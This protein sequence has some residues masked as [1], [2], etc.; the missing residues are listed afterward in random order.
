MYVSC[1]QMMKHEW[2]SDVWFQFIDLAAQTWYTCISECIV[3]F[4][5]RRKKR[6]REDFECLKLKI[7]KSC[8]KTLGGFI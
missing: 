5:K 4:K 1:T 6:E 7:T 8:C 3:D 2:S